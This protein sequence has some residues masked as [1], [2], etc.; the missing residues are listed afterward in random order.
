[1]PLVPHYPA[2]EP[3]DDRRAP[4]IGDVVDRILNGNDDPSP[5]VQ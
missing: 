1:M 5:T 4:D 3:D 2:D